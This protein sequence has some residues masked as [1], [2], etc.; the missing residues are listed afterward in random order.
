M[1]TTA[2]G[3]FVPVGHSSAS[4]RASLPPVVTAPSDAEE[5][6]AA[7]LARTPP[8]YRGDG[9]TQSLAPARQLAIVDDE[10]QATRVDVDDDLVAFCDE[11]DRS[12]KGRLGCHV[13]D[14]QAMGAAA[15]SAVGDERDV[16]TE[17]FA[18]QGGSDREHLLHARPADRALVAN[19]H[20]VAG[21]DA[22]GPHR[23]VAGGLRIEDPRRSAEVR[24]AR[25]PQ[26]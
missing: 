4:A 15:E 14:H 5:T 21:A 1:S 18:H 17:A 16:A 9:R 22:L 6:S 2:S 13:P 10:V 26:A 20:D 12:A 25:D 3:P 7:Y 8:V 19:D 23:V 24:A 11:R